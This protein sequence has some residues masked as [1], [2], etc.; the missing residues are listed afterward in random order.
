[1]IRNLPKQLHVLKMYMS[2]LLLSVITHMWLLICYI[3]TCLSIWWWYPSLFFFLTL[4][5]L[6]NY[7]YIAS[8]YISSSDI[9]TYDLSVITSW[10]DLN[11]RDIS[12]SPP[13]KIIYA[14]VY[15]SLIMN[16]FPFFLVV[17]VPFLW[18]FRNSRVT[19]RQIS[20]MWLRRAKSLYQKVFISF[21]IG[22]CYATKVKI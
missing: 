6:F 20:T 12:S 14:L 7:L 15:F 18:A 17:N 16:R 2:F 21:Y 4:S 1:M 9:I 19:L 8:R 11:K 10:L 13:K 3:I 22:T 5:L